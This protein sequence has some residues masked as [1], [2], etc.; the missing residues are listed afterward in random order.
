MEIPLQTIIFSIP[1]L[2]VIAFHKLRNVSWQDA[3]A[4]VGWRGANVR[5]LAAGLGMGLLPV[6]ML[7]V[8]RQLIPPQ[9]MSD[10]NLAN[11]QYQGWPIGIGSF[12]LAL[13]HETF[14]TALGEEVFFR[15]FLGAALIRMLG[16][17]TGNLI[18]AVVFLVPHLL[19]LTASLGLWPLL[20]AQ[21]IM[22][23]IQGWLLHRSGSILPG[24]FSHSLSNAFGALIFMG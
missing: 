16:F 21:F 18:Q 23:W 24:W 5:Y 8:L 13:M 9:V 2:A 14:Y 4:R 22:G 20:I 6:V 15:G 11:Y 12:L 3:L 7:P 10:P 17:H 19:L 1:S